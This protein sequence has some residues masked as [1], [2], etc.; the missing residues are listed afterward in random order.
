[1][2]PCGLHRQIACP[3]ITEILSKGGSELKGK[4]LLTMGIVYGDAGIGCDES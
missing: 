1:M 3:P 2:C 4:G